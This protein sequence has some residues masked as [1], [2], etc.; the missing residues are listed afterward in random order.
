M[1]LHSCRLPG[2]RS[3]QVTILKVSRGQRGTITRNFR[4]R[5]H[6]SGN[7]PFRTDF[8]FHAELFGGGMEQERGRIY[9]QANQS[10]KINWKL[11]MF[12][13]SNYNILNNSL[14]NLSGWLPSRDQI[15]ELPVIILIESVRQCIS[16][17]VVVV[18][19]FTPFTTSQQI[20]NIN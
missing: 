18:R 10:S 9:S 19:D 20:I 8:A 17:P 11:V 14:Y 6:R 7:S 3:N 5:S 1:P 12:P 2:R 13:S 15:A 16:T 4:C